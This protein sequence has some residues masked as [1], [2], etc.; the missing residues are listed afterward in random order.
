[1]L[2]GVFGVQGVPGPGSGGCPGRV[3]C[4]VVAKDRGSFLGSPHNG[5]LG[6]TGSTEKGM[7]GVNPY[8]GKGRGD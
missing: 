3:L 2:F 6:G 5:G 4:A 7:G 1:M 8:P